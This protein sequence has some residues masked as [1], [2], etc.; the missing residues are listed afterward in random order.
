MKLN[1]ADGVLESCEHGRGKLDEVT[2]PEGVE[3]IGPCSMQGLKCQKLVMPASL[4]AI[5]SEAFKG[6]KIGEI[7]FGRCQLERI[8]DEAFLDCDATASLPDSIAHIGD[9]GASG[10]KI[11]SGSVLRLPGSLCYMG[12]CAIKLG[13]LTLHVIANERLITKNSNLYESIMSSMNSF[14]KVVIIKV[15]RED[16]VINEFLIC[17]Q[18]CSKTAI[19]PY[20][21]ENG[22]NYEAYDAIFDQ[23]DETCKGLM[24]GKRCVWPFELA[25]EKKDYY[26]SYSV[27]LCLIRDKTK[28]IKFFRYLGESYHIC[29]EH[30]E[31]ILENAR[32]ANS[33]EEAAYIMDLMQRRYGATAKSIEL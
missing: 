33:V 27:M 23:V 26:W 22:I 25:K 10:L 31:E 9:Y 1:I 28:G 5:G 24:A 11:N 21:D 30:L 15:M 3:R 29:L 32:K 4:K 16:E 12:K 2:L 17:G 13:M 20:I 19:E 8:E 6:A 18:E 14:V 7:D